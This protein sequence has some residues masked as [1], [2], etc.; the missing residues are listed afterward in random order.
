MFSLTE[1][2][3]TLRN[4]NKIDLE[5]FNSVKT[6]VTQNQFEA[7]STWPI[8]PS[9]PAVG[10]VSILCDEFLHLHAIFL[11]VFEN[12]VTKL[13]LF[14][15]IKFEHNNQELCFAAHSFPCCAIFLAL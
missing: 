10:N 7:K 14:G 6:F 15:Q 4:A 5:A 11:S 9:I 2:L 13:L 3:N 1:V 8:I 12:I